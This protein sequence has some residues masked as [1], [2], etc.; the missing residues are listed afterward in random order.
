MV[1]I[2]GRI[3]TVGNYGIDPGFFTLVYPMVFLLISHKQKVVFSPLDVI[4]Y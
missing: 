4:V 3:E 1:E 2:S